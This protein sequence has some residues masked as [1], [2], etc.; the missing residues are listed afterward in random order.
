MATLFGRLP[1]TLPLVLVGGSTVPP[2]KLRICAVAAWV[3]AFPGLNWKSRNPVWPLTDEVSTVTLYT[4]AAA[5]GPAANQASA[6]EARA[7]NK[8]RLHERF[9]VTVDVNIIKVATSL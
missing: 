4:T 9:L 1:V 2:L 8:L 3:V 7:I 6:A 5:A